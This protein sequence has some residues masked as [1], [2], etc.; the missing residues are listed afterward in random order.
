MRIRL[1]NRSSIDQTYSI[2]STLPEGLNVQVLEQDKLSLAPGETAIVPVLVE[3]PREMAGS[4]KS[5]P[6]ELVIND[7]SGNQKKLEYRLLGPGR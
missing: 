4:I 1:V 6:A 2:V 3:A 5:T 7:K